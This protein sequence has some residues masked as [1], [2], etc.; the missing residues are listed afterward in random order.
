MVPEIEV[1]ISFAGRYLVAYFEYVYEV[2]LIAIS[3]GQ[4]IKREE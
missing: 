1:V 3:K 4:G 2:L